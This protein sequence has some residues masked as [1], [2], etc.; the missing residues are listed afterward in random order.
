MIFYGWTSTRTIYCERH[1]NH[2]NLYKLKTLHHNEEIRPTVVS[3]EKKC[4][5][6]KLVVIHQNICSLRKKLTIGS[7]VMF[8]VKACRCNMSHRTLAE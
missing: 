4:K 2:L 6:S 3:S 7:A 8:G 1:W 5:N